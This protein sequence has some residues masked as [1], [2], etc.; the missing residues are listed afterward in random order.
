MGASLPAKL[1]CVST[2][3]CLNFS[4]NVRTRLVSCTRPTT[5]LKI[6]LAMTAQSYESEALLIS[7]N[8]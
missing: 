7:D 6:R 5:F 8:Y 1:Y 3:P 2:F 4:L